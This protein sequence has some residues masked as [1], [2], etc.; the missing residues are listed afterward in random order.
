ML[1]LAKTGGF[2][3]RTWWRT[4]NGYTSMATSTELLPPGLRDERLD[5]VGRPGTG[6]LFLLNFPRKVLQTC[7]LKSW[8][9]GGQGIH[10]TKPLYSLR[11]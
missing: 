8:L 4:G 7:S 2:E 10:K 1:E 5:D 3:A 6:Q 11:I 9:S